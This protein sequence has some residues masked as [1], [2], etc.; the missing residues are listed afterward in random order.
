MTPPAAATVLA[1]EDDPVTRADLRFVLED[2]GFALCPDAQDGLEAVRLARKHTPDVILLD[3]GLPILDGIEA[4]RR[5]LS[6]RDVPIVAL[7][8]Y[9]D[10]LGAQALEAGA[11]SYVRKPFAAA[12]VVDAV[13]DA[14]AHDRPP[15]AQSRTTLGE[16][17]AMLGY[18]AEWA[19]A[20]ERR[21]WRVQR[22]DWQE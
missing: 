9:G 11:R 20:L 22:V 5:I 18:P 15:V 7:T 13:W 1:V 6:E 14:L 12:E 10:D 19:D 8:G 21:G 16:V 4:A 3:V 17:L 2:A